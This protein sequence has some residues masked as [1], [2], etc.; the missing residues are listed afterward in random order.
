MSIFK[1]LY[2]QFNP[3]KTERKLFE[4]EAWRNLRYKQSIEGKR[5]A[6]INKEIHEIESKYFDDFHPM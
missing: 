1:W 4:E 3:P 6:E 5:Q 2:E